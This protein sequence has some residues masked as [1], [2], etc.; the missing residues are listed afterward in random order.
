MSADRSDITASDP[1][2]GPRRPIYV[3]VVWRGFLQAA[4]EKATP[5]TRVIIWGPVWF[6][7]GLYLQLTEG[8]NDLRGG[9]VC[10]CVCVCPSEIIGHHLG[11]E[12]RVNDSAMMRRGTEPFSSAR[13]HS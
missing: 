6:T 13:S 5:R 10:V 11:G 3:H 9:G 7:T 12:P 4:H 2:A 1:D 8:R